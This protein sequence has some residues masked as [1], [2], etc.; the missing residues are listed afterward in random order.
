[1][2]TSG[3]SVWETETEERDLLVDQVDVAETDAFPEHIRLLLGLP[4][5]AATMVRSRRHVLDGKPVLLS[6]S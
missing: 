5:G 1:M 2:K 4:D 3:V 6:R